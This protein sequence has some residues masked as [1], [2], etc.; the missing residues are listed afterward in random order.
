MLELRILGGL[1]LHRTADGSAVGTPRRKPLALLALLA[2][3]GG[4]GMARERLVT[5]LWPEEAPER[6]RRSLAQ[7]LYAL[8]RETGAADVVTGDE[9]LRLGAAVVDSDLARFREALAAGDAAAVVRT[10]GG[11]LL[12]GAQFRGCREF[13]RWVD[14]Q[15]AS[16][17]RAYVGAVLCVARAAS[18]RGDPATAA[19]LLERAFAEDPH[20]ARVAV[21][22]AEAMS[23][24]GDRTGALRVLDGHRAVL[25]ADLDVPPDPAVLTAREALRD[26][27]PPAPTVRLPRAPAA[28]AAATAVPAATPASERERGTRPRRLGFVV[29]LTALALAAVAVV[30]HGARDV[31]AEH[32]APAPLVTV[33]A[34]FGTAGVAPGLRH[35]RNGLPELVAPLFDE[36]DPS[37]ERG[38][39]P[40]STGEPTARWRALRVGGEPDAD[41]ASLLD[42]ARAH[43]ARRLLVGALVG[44]ASRLV[45][46]ATLLDA[47]SGVVRAR[48]Q[49]AGPADSVPAMA[50]RIGNE[51]L[52]REAGE[53]PE[54]VAA[55]VRVPPSAMRAF[56]DGRRAYRNGRFATA[57]RRFTVVGRLA[58]GLPL[59]DVWIAVT[60]NWTGDRDLAKAAI[61]RAWPMR[62]SLPAADRAHL[63]AL[64]GPRYPAR[65][66][67]RERL[68]A[69]HLVTRQAP[70]RPDGWNE[71]GEAYF[72]QG[73]LL[74]IDHA[75][76]RARTAFERALE[77]DPGHQ[78]SRLH[79]AQLLAEAGD[80]ASV[81]AHLH[82]LTATDSSGES[83]LFVRW[84]LAVLLGDSSGARALA[85]R[86]ADV[87]P[88]P[89]R[90]LVESAVDDAVGID[91]ARRVLTLRESEARTVAERADLARAH[92]A[93]ALAIGRP[94]EG[95][96]AVR[97]L[98]A[99]EPD[100]SRNRSLD[101]LAAL[102]EDGSADAAGRASRALTTRVLS[103]RV[104]GDGPARDTLMD[105]ACVAA[106]W[107]RQSGDTVAARRLRTILRREIAAPRP[108]TD[109]VVGARA[110]A[111]LL[112]ADLAPGAR[113]RD[114][115]RLALDS[116]LADGHYSGRSEPY[117]PLAVTLA[118]L[119]AGDTARAL[120]AVRRV[121]YFGRWPYYIGRLLTLDAQ[122]SLA[123]ADTV[124]A[125]C[126]VRQLAVLRARAEAPQRAEADRLRGTVAP[127]ERAWR[128]SPTRATALIRAPRR[129]PACREALTG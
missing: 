108:E 4:E 122:L 106:Q 14:A 102:Y 9:T 78:P 56:L 82:R 97:W 74:G 24:T 89:T 29:R 17:L 86:L 123:G 25:A 35:L 129:A 94:L 48:A 87:S 67:M 46:T 128:V 72:H 125:I 44:D 105:A 77:L 62:D 68:A 50:A 83:A 53:L 6:G 69:W 79:L 32:E 22:L 117:L 99:V 110:C 1:S 36:A 98:L 21:A 124:G 58:P 11:P 70:D 118:H 103:A 10:Y 28:A 66:S 113:E 45:V 34:P 26:A 126:A 33:V 37:D 39:A 38:D 92:H 27:T 54:D 115:A 49:T 19:Q 3:A 109:A 111:H 52:A 47:A 2:W 85:P 63:V 23:A 20:D 41:A 84:R 8:R 75:A 80:A 55:L 31:G 81:R 12:D 60:A 42:S 91:D 40:P 101:V 13:E 43:G 116:L 93:L 51:L 107:Q 16:L 5:M 120:R 119:R 90:W 76:L 65:S 61:A 59:V 96:A 57:L 104:G 100:E 71:V 88:Q 73:E 15:R 30:V 114:A 121:T 127:A 112:D 7:T 64:A 18:A 95:S